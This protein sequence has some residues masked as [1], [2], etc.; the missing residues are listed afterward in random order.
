MVITAGDIAT[1]PCLAAHQAS[2]DDAAN[3]GI[4]GEARSI[5]AQLHE[6]I[7]LLEQGYFPAIV[8]TVV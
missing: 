4:G 2:T 5:V 6:L 7:M 3:M 1:A 8:C